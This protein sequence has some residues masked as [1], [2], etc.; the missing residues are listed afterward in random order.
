MVG[1]G[2][3]HWPVANGGLCIDEVADLDR[4]ED[5]IIWS[6]EILRTA[7]KKQGCHALYGARADR[8]SEGNILRKIQ[9]CQS[10]TTYS[11]LIRW[12]LL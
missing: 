11:L 3:A 6:A 4:I 10:R 9:R 7:L 8:I 1:A 5:W 12:T 2:N